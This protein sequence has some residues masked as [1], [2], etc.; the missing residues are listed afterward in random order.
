MAHKKG[1]G[2]CRNGRDSNPQFRGFKLYGGQAARAGNIILRQ[3]G[4]KFTAGANVGM[5]HDYTL[6]ATADGLVSMRGRK[7]DVVPQ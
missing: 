2:A 7:I 5:G 6:F 3:R 4:T 1:G